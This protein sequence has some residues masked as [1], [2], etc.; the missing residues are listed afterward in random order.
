MVDVFLVR[1]GPL[2]GVVLALLV[3]LPVALLT[4]RW[5]VRRR[6][7]SI[8][9]AYGWPA[10]LENALVG[11]SMFLGGTIESDVAVQA[12]DGSGEC[13][14]SSARTVAASDVVDSRGEG[15][16]LRVGARTVVIHGPLEVAHGS[17]VAAIVGAPLEALR[18]E[19]G[20]NADE[21]AAIRAEIVSSGDP[22]LVAGTLREAPSDYRG[23]EIVL[24]DARVV[25]LNQKVRATAGLALGTGL[26]AF[27]VTLG[28]VQLVALRA[29]NDVPQ[30]F[31]RSEAR[32]HV[33]PLTTAHRVALVAFSRDRA[34]ERI[35]QIASFARPT[36]EAI[37]LEADASEAR[38]RCSLAL[39]VLASHGLRDEARERAAR[40]EPRHVAR[41]MAAIERSDGRLEDALGW[42]SRATPPTD[43]R[44]AAWWSA[45]RV[46]LA[47]EAGRY[48]EALA[49]LG[50][51]ADD[52]SRE[53]VR[54]ALLTASGRPTPVAPER[55]AACHLLRAELEGYAMRDWLQRGRLEERLGALAAPGDEPMGSWVHIDGIET[56]ELLEGTLRRWDGLHR[57]ALDGAMR[58]VRDDPDLTGA[59]CQLAAAR[60]MHAYRRT[61]E[62]QPR[63]EGCDFDQ[64]AVL[65]ALDT[66]A[67]LPADTEVGNLVPIVSRF[68]LEPTLLH[69]REL[70]RASRPHFFIHDYRTEEQIAEADRREHEDPP[71]PEEAVAME[72]DGRALE[73]MTDLRT[74]WFAASTHREELLAW[75]ALRQREIGSPETSLSRLREVAHDDLW[76]ARARGDADAIA[77]AEA[78]VDRL[79]EALDDRRRV[80]LL[81]AWA[82]AHR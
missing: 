6:R 3:A 4:M 62:P 26:V 66:G 52:R 12:H 31:V 65:V 9:A 71:T 37:R 53:C 55:D 80:V 40:C 72:G 22:V 39:E 78:R 49:L 81:A 73:R 54:S 44:D 58:R 43:A 21:L 35:G 15:G 16:R 25:S 41:A 47:L 30:T 74:A 45:F 36:L 70:V 68:R 48:E 59:R 32:T 18:K 34:L 8:Y 75:L 24:S 63:V 11:E 5:L 61:G 67:P 13:L 57:D 64:L 17:R 77:E 38:G 79:S 50:P 1:H 82:R 69:L 20:A 42:A 10:P 14:A 29:V 56:D 2:V 46:Q 7:A 60:A 76:I 19:L 28:V 51:A 33:L 27:A 23:S